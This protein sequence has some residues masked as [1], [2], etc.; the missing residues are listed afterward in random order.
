MF[1]EYPVKK[2]KANKSTNSQVKKILKSKIIKGP[3]VITL[4]KPP[5]IPLP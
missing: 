1:K 3:E 5:N 4:P 2:R